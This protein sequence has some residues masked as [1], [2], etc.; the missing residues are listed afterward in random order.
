LAIQERISALDAQ[1]QRPLRGMQSSLNFLAGLLDISNHLA[2]EAGP[3]R[4]SQRTDALQ[5]QVVVLAGSERH[6]GRQSIEPRDPE[7]STKQR[8]GDHS[9]NI[10]GATSLFQASPISLRGSI[11][12][13]HTQVETPAD[14]VTIRRLLTDNSG[15]TRRFG[16]A[17]TTTAP[18]T[19]RADSGQQ[20]GLRV[21]PAVAL[22]AARR[23]IQ[24]QCALSALNCA[25][26][27]SFQNAFSDAK[28]PTRSDSGGYGELTHQP[29]CHRLDQPSAWP[30][31]DGATAGQYQPG[32]LPLQRDRE[33][34]HPTVSRDQWRQNWQ[35]EARYTFNQKASSGLLLDVTRAELINI[36]SASTGSNNVAR[37][38][39][40]EWRWSYRLLPDLT[41]TQRNTL[42]PTMS[43]TRSARQQP[44]VARLRL[45]NRE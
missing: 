43:N 21:G 16:G 8:T 45:R 6:G 30:A 9:E 26:D 40:A 20:A 2:R 10:R 15:A 36:P 33:V 37:S 28:F 18:S 22:D 23:F 29:Q 25:I 44:A 27:G 35:A 24:C 11:T 13:R 12:Y 32:L 1:P 41:V 17:S 19:W 38:Y 31:H 14:T 3:V 4:Q 5:P 34:R 7:S 42:G 39:S